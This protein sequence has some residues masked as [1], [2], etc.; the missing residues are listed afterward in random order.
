MKIKIVLLVFIYFYMSLHF[1]SCNK[2]EVKNTDD[3]SCLNKIV[4]FEDYYL[5]APRSFNVD[6]HLGEDSRVFNIISEKEDIY[7]GY[8]YMV[9]DERD[10]IYQIPKEFRRCTDMLEIRDNSGREVGICFYR[11]LP[12]SYRSCEGYF[13]VKKENYYLA[14]LRLDYAIDKFSET[15]EIINSINNK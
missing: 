4:F 11:N 2:E 7:I 1:L 9:L 13:L 14:I 15:I 12:G 6:D 8:E 5:Y 3:V 10:I